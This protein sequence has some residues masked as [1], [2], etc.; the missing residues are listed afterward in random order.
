MRWA[1]VKQSKAK[2]EKVCSGPTS[3]ETIQDEKMQSW[4]QDRRIAKIFGE[5][6]EKA[7]ASGSRQLRKVEETQT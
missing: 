1:H 3:A 2:Q 5:P 4:K 7:L 6:T